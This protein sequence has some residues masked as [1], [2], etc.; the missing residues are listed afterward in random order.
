MATTT[1][2]QRINLILT[3]LLL[4]DHG[5]WV[6]QC[7]EYDVT[8][9]GK[10][11]DEAMTAFERTLVGQVLLDTEQ[12]K[13]PLSGIGQAPKQFFDL[14]KKARRLTDSVPFYVPPQQPNVLVNARVED[15]RICA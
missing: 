4:Q 14:S 9:Q 8:A 5:Y 3:I 13:Q 6:A 1:Q 11:I 2:V 12:G 15:L 7:L 10:N